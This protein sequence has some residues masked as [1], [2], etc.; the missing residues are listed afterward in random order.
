MEFD[1][2]T[3]VPLNKTF[4]GNNCF[5]RI[6]TGDHRNAAHGHFARHCGDGDQC[7]DMGVN[8]MGIELT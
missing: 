3:I 4:F 2:L 8:A 6:A 7:N 5:S 1:L